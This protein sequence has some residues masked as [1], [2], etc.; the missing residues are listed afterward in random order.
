[1]SNESD[2]DQL[3]LAWW[4][5]PGGGKGFFTIDELEE[6]FEQFLLQVCHSVNFCIRTTTVL[7]RAQ[8]RGLQVW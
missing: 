3:H 8:R 1:M 7:N 5:Y 4:A 6:A 2:S